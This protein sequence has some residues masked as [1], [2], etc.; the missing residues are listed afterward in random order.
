MVWEGRRRKASSYPDCP[1]DILEQLR[2]RIDGLGNCRT[3]F[4]YIF[5]EKVAEIAERV[6]PGSF[7]GCEFADIF[8]HRANAIS[9]F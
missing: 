4:G 2:H 3:P 6:V 1:G 8:A 9:G 5:D 7:Q